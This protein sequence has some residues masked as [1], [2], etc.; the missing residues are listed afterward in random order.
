[1]SWPGNDLRLPRLKALATRTAT[2]QLLVSYLRDMLIGSHSR[3]VEFDIDDFG[4]LMRDW[5]VSFMRGQLSIHTIDHAFG[6][7]DH[8]N[9]FSPRVAKEFVGS[10]LANRLKPDTRF[11]SPE[12]ADFVNTIR[13]MTSTE[14]SQRLMRE[15]LAAQALYI[16]A[17][18]HGL[19]PNA[20]VAGRAAKAI[21]VTSIPRFLHVNELPL[22]DEQ[23][24]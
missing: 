16:R 23:L 12:I 3:L 5:D 7:T 4:Q 17:T 2:M 15:R 1:M 9:N 18:G 11:Y 24:A 20:N 13:H 14:T 8:L 19:F 22:F 10:V 6:C 21:H